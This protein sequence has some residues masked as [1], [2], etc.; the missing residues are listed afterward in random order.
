MDMYT[1]KPTNQQPVLAQGVESS[2]PFLS[3]H[4]LKLQFLV[5]RNPA[6]PFRVGAAALA[7]MP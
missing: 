3:L 5:V 4:F 6:R 7:L 1:L 2:L